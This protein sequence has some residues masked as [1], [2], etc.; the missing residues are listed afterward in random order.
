MTEAAAKPIPFYRRKP[1]R[2]VAIVLGV[3]LLAII[4]LVLAFDWNWLKGPVERQVQAQTGREL[5]IGGNL[6]VDLG[7]VTT[8]RA[9]RLSFGN[10]TWSKEPTM[11]SADRAEFDV[12]IW[13]LLFERQ[14]RIP[15]IRLSKPALRLET[16]PNGVGNWVFGDPDGEPIR[17]GKIW[18]D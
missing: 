7:R 18:I 3:L 17:F 16:G 15:E 13:P 8:I 11:A 12:E 14:T 10:A 2:P 4:I 9:D 5:H 1:S 6:H